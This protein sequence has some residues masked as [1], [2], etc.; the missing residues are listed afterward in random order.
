MA[1]PVRLNTGCELDDLVCA[2][3][4]R[5]PFPRAAAGGFKE[6]SYAHAPPQALCFGSSSS[7]CKA[8]MVGCLEDQLHI[9]LRITAI[10][11]HP[12][13]SLVGIASDQVQTPELNRIPARLMGREV[14]QSLDDIVGLGLTGA[15][16]GINRNGVGEHA[17]YLHANRRNCIESALS[18]RCCIGRAARSSG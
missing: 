3:S 4:H 16:I 9:R 13:G 6:A 14:N 2:K 17:S 1:L 5:R 18:R 11:R 12:E 15:T 7:L 10:Y 8:C